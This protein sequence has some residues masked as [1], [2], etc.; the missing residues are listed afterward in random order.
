MSYLCD[1]FPVKRD[2][3]GISLF[4]DAF[5]ERLP[6]VLDSAHVRQTRPSPSGRFAFSMEHM[7]G[8]LSGG[9]S[10]WLCLCPPFGKAWK[11]A[12]IPSYGSSCYFLF[13]FTALAC[14]GMDAPFIR[15]PGC[16]A[17]PGAFGLHRAAVLCGF[18]PGPDA[19]GMVFQNRS[20]FFKRPLFFIRRKQRGKYGGAHRIPFS[21]RTKPESRGTVFPL[22]FWLYGACVAHYAERPHALRRYPSGFDGR[23]CAL[24]R[25]CARA[26]APEMAFAFFCPFKPS[27]RGNYPHYNGHSGGAA[28]LDY[29]PDAVSAFFRHGLRQETTSA[30]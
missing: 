16:L 11:M 5:P 22:A 13:Q 26:Q 18:R 21:H 10:R 9:S 6:P 12:A 30:A 7:H 15:K 1:K 27:P 25:I 17:S 19:P 28:S 14:S 4:S 2:L 20:P 23:I 8:L 24:R 3:H 29:P